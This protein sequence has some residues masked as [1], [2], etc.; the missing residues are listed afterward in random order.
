MLLPPPLAFGAILGRDSL[1]KGEWEG[2]ATQSIAAPVIF[3][4]ATPVAT[5]LCC[6]AWVFSPHTGIVLELG[7]PEVER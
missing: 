4:K 5:Q 7:L 2:L 3:T 6:C 1:P